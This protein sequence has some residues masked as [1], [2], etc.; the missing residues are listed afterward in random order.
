MPPW[1]IFED[2]DD[3]PEAKSPF[4]T[5]AVL[6]PRLAASSATPAPVIPPPMTSTSNSSSARRRRASSRRKGCTG[7]ACHIRH[8]GHLG[9]GGDRGGAPPPC[10]GRSRR[11]GRPCHRARTGSPPPPSTRR[12]PPCRSDGAIRGRAT[13]GRSSRS[14]GSGVGD[15]VVRP[16]SPATWASGHG[17]R[18]IRCTSS[19][20]GTPAASG[21]A[22]QTTAAARRRWR[23]I[24]ARW[25]SASVVGRGVRSG[26]GPPRGGSGG[27]AAPRSG[28]PG[29]GRP[30]R[31]GRHL[32][33]DAAGMDHRGLHRGKAGG[34]GLV[35]GEPDPGR[36]P[37]WSYYVRRSRVAV[38]PRRSASAKGG[39]GRSNEP[40]V[41]ILTSLAGGPKHGYA[42][43]KDIEAIR[44]RLPRPGDPLRRH[45]PARGAGAHRARGRRQRRATAPLPHH[46]C[47]PGRA[48]GSRARHAAAGRRGCAP[49]R[50]RRHRS[51][52]R[53]ALV[54]PDRYE[55]LLRWYPRE[56]RDRYGGEMTAL[57]EDS[58]ATAERC[59]RARPPE[60]RPP[61]P[62][63][64]GAHGWVR[65]CGARCRRRSCE[66]VPSS[67]CAAGPSFLSP[68]PSSENSQTTGGSG[69]PRS[70]GCPRAS[71][72]TRWR[73]SGCW[74]ARSL[75]L[76]RCWPL[77]SFVRLV[78]AGRWSTVRRPVRRAGLAFVVA[79]VLLGGGLA[80]A[81]H[82]GPHDR[83]GGLAV[84]SAA[85]VVIGL[86][87]FVAIRLGRRRGGGG[88]PPRRPARTRPARA[89]SDGP[90][91]LGR[92]DPVLRR[93]RDL[94]G[95]AGGLRS[96]PSC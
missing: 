38:M 65:R 88:G 57:L 32:R 64:T 42:L 23:P 78:R 39:L 53:A 51:G 91:P 71:A 58:Y 90:R 19:P 34:V 37:P 2:F 96:R 79:A 10:R 95:D 82:L 27:P 15:L 40:P 9:P 59:A 62:G 63:G 36:E 93:L 69:R 5:S 1:T 4:S 12:V 20:P 18:P 86:A 46:R 13:R 25:P 47:R 44:R 45:H 35:H 3:V 31:P 24:C 28:R 21:R 22:R 68:A 74:A 11:A 76:L 61:R 7:Q 84:Y 50:H 33:L 83:N 60:P 49:P 73:C 67:S 87:A 29:L 16:A 26:V 52:H 6:R 72:S 17:R 30:L 54:S 70:T 77:P 8:R 89:G 92:D 48:R 75:P 66:P 43:T 85:F 41:L 56:W 14:S 55:R 80:W 81:H 94:V